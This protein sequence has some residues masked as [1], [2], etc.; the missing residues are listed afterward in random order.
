MSKT[1]VFGIASNFPQANRIVNRLK[2]AGIAEDRI[3]ALF[4]HTA[5]TRAV[6]EPH[7]KAT[8]AGAAGARTAS[9]FGAGL[10]W[11]VGTGTVAIPGIGSIVAAGPIMAALGGA[12]LGAAV[13][14]LGGA[15]VGLGVPEYEATRYE[16]KI[17][18]GYVVIAVHPKDKWEASRAEEI[19]KR[20]G[21]HRISDTEVTVKKSA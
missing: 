21:A 4:H 3:S 19:F 2:A 10:G 9:L 16:G 7:T 13:G 1:A 15:L 11:L 20:Q 6:R 14:G 5:D 8:E 12:A 18:E 17:R